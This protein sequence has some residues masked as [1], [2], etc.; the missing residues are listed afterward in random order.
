M[1]FCL[2]PALLLLAPFHRHFR[3]RR[4]SVI[5]VKVADGDVF[6]AVDQQH[7]LLAMEQ[8]QSPVPP[9]GQVPLPL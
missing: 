1:H 5:E 4:Y 9:E 6:A 8:K 2:H 7:R 3:Y